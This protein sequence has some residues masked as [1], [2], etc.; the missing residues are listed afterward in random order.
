MNSWTLKSSIKLQGEKTLWRRDTS[1][2]HFGVEVHRVGIL[3]MFGGEDTQQQAA[4]LP[5]EERLL[6]SNAHQI[7]LRPLHARSARPRSLVSTPRRSRSSTAVGDATD[8]VSDWERATMDSVHAASQ[9]LATEAFVSTNNQTS[10]DLTT[11]NTESST[12]QVPR[13]TRQPIR[14]NTDALSNRAGRPDH[15]N[16]ANKNRKP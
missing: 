5:S 10:E 6:A 15:T 16:V 4:L 12:K 7:P 14:Q 11:H 2:F 3:A 8:S 1:D 13:P 9:A